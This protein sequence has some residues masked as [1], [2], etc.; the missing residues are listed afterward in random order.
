MGQRKKLYIIQMEVSFG[1]S[2]KKWV[3]STEV[4]VKK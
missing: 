2:T 4:D 3:E 1:R